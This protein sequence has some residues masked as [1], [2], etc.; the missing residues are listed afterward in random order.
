MHW[1]R[2]AS[3][4]P[5]IMSLFGRGSVSVLLRA[6]EW[7]QV[8]REHPDGSQ[9]WGFPRPGEAKGSPDGTAVRTEM[10]WDL[11]LSPARQLFSWPS[12][13]GQGTEQGP[14]QLRPVR[15]RAS[16]CP[17]RPLWGVSW[18]HLQPSP[19]PA[20]HTLCPGLRLGPLKLLVIRHSAQAGAPWPLR[21]GA[22]PAW[23]RKHVP[24]WGPAAS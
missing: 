6:E 19:A 4:V 11:S 1:A 21:S 18:V 24:A 3:T 5:L 9:P 2:L 8:C 23:N 13:Q 17:G 14:G 20:R 15:F 12:G 10:F 16:G 7:G 22:A